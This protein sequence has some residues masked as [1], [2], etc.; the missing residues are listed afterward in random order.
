MVWRDLVL[1][2][3][4]LQRPLPGLATPR[5][6][7]LW[8]FPFGSK[9]DSRRLLGGSLGCDGTVGFERRGVGADGAADHRSTRPERLDRARQPDVRGRRALDRAYGLSLA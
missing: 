7:G 1:M 4:P 9:S 2:A 3:A 8:G 5:W 6:W